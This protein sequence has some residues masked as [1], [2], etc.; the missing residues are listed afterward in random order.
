VEE[1]GGRGTFVR[2]LTEIEVQSEA[3]ALNLLFSGELSR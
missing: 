3:E 2:G 1:P